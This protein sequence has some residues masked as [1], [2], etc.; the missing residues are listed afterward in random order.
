MA[1]SRAQRAGAGGDSTAAHTGARTPA[2]WYCY[3]VGAVLAL[4]GILGFAADASFGMGGTVQGGSLLG[5]EV[6]GWHN[7]VHLLSGVVLLA[8]AGKRRTA[9]PAAIA[10]GAVYGLVTVIGLLDGNDVLGLIPVNVADNILHVAL[11]LLG[12][13]A[14][15]MSRADDDVA[16]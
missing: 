6:N 4:V 10:F 16:R 1:Q 7:V 5:F 13:A 3:I 15:F 2:Q 11:S 12:L 9:K 8:L 14:G